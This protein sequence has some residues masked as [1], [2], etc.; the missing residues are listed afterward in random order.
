MKV[1]IVGA[2][3]AGIILARA[4]VGP[5]KHITLIDSG[6]FYGE[7]E[8]INKSAYDFQ[9]NSRMPEGVH[10]VGGGANLWY[11]RVSQFPD[12]VFDN[13]FYGWPMSAEEIRP[14]YL[15]LYKILK[16]GEMTDKDFCKIHLQRIQ[17]LLL[18]QLEISPYFNCEPEYFQEMLSDLK[19]SKNVSIKLDSP[20]KSINASNTDEKFLEFSD[21]S[22]EPYDKIVISAGAFQS[23]AILI[24]SI[25]QLPL[26]KNIES[27]GTRLMEHYDG[28][29]G[30]LKIRKSRLQDFELMVS[31][32]KSNSVSIYGD[33]R[34]FGFGIKLPLQ[35]YLDSNLKFLDFHLHFEPYQEIYTFGDLYYLIPRGTNIKRALFRIERII[36]KLLIIPTRKLLDFCFG[37]VRFSVYMKG[38]EAPFIE[39][40]LTLTNSPAN[41]LGTLVYNHRISRQTTKLMRVSLREFKRRFQD[42]GFGKIKLFWWFMNNTGSAYAGPNWHPMGTIPMHLDPSISVVNPDLSLVNYPDIYMLNSG[43]YPSGSYQNPAATILALALRLSKTLHKP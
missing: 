18:G 5:G 19:N 13:K 21:G 16:L 41:H 1:A 23:T 24:R 29:I 17:D 20:V 2:G 35:L 38:E 39:S 43:I 9:T 25:D 10:K 7:S 14:Y 15:E 28:Y 22:L 11:G 8:L 6:N 27:V 26:M 37:V 36:R 40:T 31:G 4:L 32:S 30:T 3:Q 34:S 33:V 12:Y 42:L